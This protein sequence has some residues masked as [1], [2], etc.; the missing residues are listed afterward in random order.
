M[1]FL[2]FSFS[3]GGWGAGHSKDLFTRVRIPG[4]DPEV[5][6]NTS[7]PLKCPGTQKDIFLQFLSFFSPGPEF[8]T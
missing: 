6:E 3:F 7:G 8:M 5:T 1:L 4:L 2:F